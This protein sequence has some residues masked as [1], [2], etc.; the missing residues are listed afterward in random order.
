[1]KSGSSSSMQVRCQQESWSSRSKGRVA[2]ERSRQR[3][4]IGCRKDLGLVVVCCRRNGR[5]VYPSL[6]WPLVTLP[7]PVQ[8]LLP[9]TPQSSALRP[10]APTIFCRAMANLL[11]PSTHRSA[12]GA[13]GHADKGGGA[14]SSPPSN[15][16]RSSPAGRGGPPQQPAPPAA[17][18]GAGMQGAPLHLLSDVVTQLCCHPHYRLLSLR[19]IPQVRNVGASL[20]PGIFVF[21]SAATCVTFLGLV[22]TA[23]FHSLV[24]LAPMSPCLGLIIRVLCSEQST[25][26]NPL[27]SPLLVLSRAAS[28]KIVCTSSI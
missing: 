12:A 17:G 9:C 24:H 4:H 20:P 11:L 13:A 21:A 25:L 26:N 15:Q 18:Q 1:M 22:L 5:V 16:P 14:A 8:L 7:L 3:R 2:N 23:A 10:A 6:Q 28:A 27:L 19:S